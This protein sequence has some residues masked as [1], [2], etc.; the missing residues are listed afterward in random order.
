M[1]V[2]G[3]EIGTLL[4]LTFRF[5]VSPT[6]VDSE[7]IYSIAVEFSFFLYLFLLFCCAV[8][9][10]KGMG[11]TEGRVLLILLG[12]EFGSDG[13]PPVPEPPLPGRLAME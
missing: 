1:C 10:A 12:G 3:E 2:G 13:D 9:A 5:V 8:L 7:D 4:A 11:I 6:R